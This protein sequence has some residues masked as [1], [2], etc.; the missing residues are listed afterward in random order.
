M[1][2]IITGAAG[3]IG[4]QA[5]ARFLA[6]GDTVVAVDDLS[7]RGAVA[8]MEWLQGQGGD[9]RFLGE[10]ILDPRP[11]RRLLIAH[12]DADAMLHLAAQTAVTTS[13]AAP[14]ADFAVNAIGTFQ[15]LDTI[16][17]LGLT[18][19]PFLYSS[20]NKVYGDLGRCVVANVR[21]KGKVHRQLA[22]RHDGIGEEEPL[23]FHTP[24]GCSKGA[25]DQYTLDHARTFGL[26]TVVFRQSCIYG[27]RQLG[28][29]DQGWMAWFAAAALL[30]RPVT[31]YGDGG[32]VRDVLWIDD[33]LDAFEMAVANIGH[34][35]GEAFNI[36]G[37]PENT[38][39]LLELLDMLREEL[40]P[41]PDPAF[42]GWRP[43]DQLCYVSDIRKA[44]RKL[45]WRP[46]VDPGRGVPMLLEWVSSH[47]DLFR[48]VVPAG[49][50]ARPGADVR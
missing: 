2:W 36:G 14:G 43:G 33:L 50:S 12:G 41:I 4:C 6:R 20:T 44:E 38:L 8:N 22:N 3:F 47:L 27:R 26:K 19:L 42:A 35:A 17:D 28:V 16:R 30:G 5:A 34:V 18:D 40:G 49:P 13:I 45:G 25:A 31:I 1:K 39:S 29:E 46:V 23:D 9:L 21:H 11:V 37:G 7:R 32:Q 10:S 48:S 15:V 24:Y